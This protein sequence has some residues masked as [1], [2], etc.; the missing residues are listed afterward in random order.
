MSEVIKVP[1]KINGV[2]VGEAIIDEDGTIHLNMHGPSALGK[3]M[4]EQITEGL[5]TALTIAPIISSRMEVFFASDPEKNKPLRNI[6]HFRP[7]R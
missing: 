5:L 6:K 2:V 4:R 1:A 7:L 3:E